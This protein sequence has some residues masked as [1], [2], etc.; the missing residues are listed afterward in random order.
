MRLKINCILISA[1]LCYS[2]GCAPKSAKLQKSVVPPDKTL[3]ETGKNYLQRGQYIKSRLTFQT[4][5]NTYPD[6]DM[7]SDAVFAMADS[8]YEEGGLENLLQAEDEYKN[9]IIFYPASPKAPEAQLKIISGNERLMRAPDRDQQYSYRTLKEIE[10]FEKQ[11]PESDY[12]PIVEKLKK[13]VQDVLAQHDYAIGKFYGDKGNYQAA[14]S[15]YQ[16]ITEKYKNYSEMDNIY[17][18]M[19]SSLEKGKNSKEAAIYY[20][21]LVQGYPFSPLSEEANARLKALGQEAP[22]VDKELAAQ[23]QL[24]VKPSEGFAPWKPFVA[25]VSELGF[26]K[27][28]DVYK[29]VQK[30]QEADKARA[31]EAA[32]AAAAAK[33]KESGQATEEIGGI[34]AKDSKGETSA[35]VINPNSSGA[36]QNNAS[37]KSAPTTRYKKKIAKK[38]P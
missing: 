13:R 14:V 2:Y 25:F 18:M 6:S 12:L 20:G 29:E 36:S 16:E 10:R 7:A 24:N 19:G 15:R 37:N 33:A 34:I 21:K 28:H 17:F 27:Q 8:Y 32:D 35:T 4:L 11:Y 30:N 3:F 31:A 5:I 23:N 9:F 1:I 22:S 26:G 38:T